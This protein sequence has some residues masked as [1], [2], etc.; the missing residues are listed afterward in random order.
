MRKS[1]KEESMAPKTMDGTAFGS[2]LGIRVDITAENWKLNEI[3]G[4]ITTENWKKRLA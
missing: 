4:D 2:N 1:A 3:K